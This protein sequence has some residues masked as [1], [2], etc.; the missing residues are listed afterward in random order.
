MA[1]R[2]GTPYLRVYAMACRGL[3][4][5]VTGDFEE[6]IRSLVDALGF[7]RRQR[8]GLESE[9]RILA[10]LAN[11][12]R[13]GGD[14]VSSMSAAT[15]AIEAATL[16]RMRLARCLGHIVRSQLARGHQADLGSAE[17]LVKETGALIFAPF[18][19]A[20]KEKLGAGHEPPGDSAMVG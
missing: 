6:A 2:S 17:A 19:R 4:Y 10:D 20:I 5:I 11:A 16:R 14:S 9:P 8:A 15:E 1:M 7:A 13:L 3:S 12:Y 18:I